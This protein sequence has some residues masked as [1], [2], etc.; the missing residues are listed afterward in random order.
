MKK[1]LLFSISL[2]L[3]SNAFSVDA[4]RPCRAFEHSGASVNPTKTMLDG[5]TL[6]P[7]LASPLYASTPAKFAVALFP[8]FDAITQDSVSDL[9]TKDSF[10]AQVA[11]TLS[12]RWVALTTVA[13]VYLYAKNVLKMDDNAKIFDWMMY[14]LYGQYAAAVVAARLEKVDAIN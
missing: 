6:L 10:F 3:A 13:A 14:A 1:T 4:T 12:N 7:A 8:F 11:T 2:L 9:L 5:L